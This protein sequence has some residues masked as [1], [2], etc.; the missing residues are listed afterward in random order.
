METPTP[1]TFILTQN[2]TKTYQYDYYVDQQFI[3]PSDLASSANIFELKYSNVNFYNLDIFTEDYLSHVFLLSR[4][5]NNTMYVQ[6][7]NFHWMYYFISSTFGY[8]I[9]INYS[10]LD[11]SRQTRGILTMIV[12]CNPTKPIINSYK[13][14][15]SYWYGN[16]YDE[17]FWLSALASY[18]NVQFINNTF[19]M[20][21]PASWVGF[22]FTSSACAHIQPNMFIFENNTVTT[23][24]SSGIADGSGTANSFKLSLGVNVD[25][26]DPSI[27]F[28]VSVKNNIFKQFVIRSPILDVSSNLQQTEIIFENNTIEGLYLDPDSNLQNAI[29][30][31]NNLQQ[32]SYFTIKYINTVLFENNMFKDL[33]MTQNKIL[34]VSNAQSVLIQNINASNISKIMFFNHKF[35]FL[36]FILLDINSKFKY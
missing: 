34:S 24:N 8:Q 14:M 32:Q 5:N 20:I 29:I 19:D 7:C 1:S 2:Y 3:L 4:N 21:S 26:P 18:G 30:E 31:I 25:F 9:V 17:Y 11:Q 16:S 12:S 28:K 15:N 35:S 22:Q 13:V 27:R 33:I 10:K 23:Q 6:N 36:E